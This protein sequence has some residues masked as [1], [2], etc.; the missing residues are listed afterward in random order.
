MCVKILTVD[1]WFMASGLIKQCFVDDFHRDRLKLLKKAYEE[2][3]STREE[4]NLLDLLERRW[5][6]E[7]NKNYYRMK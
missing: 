4:E 1:G 3:L 2:G 5:Q 7:I 6:K